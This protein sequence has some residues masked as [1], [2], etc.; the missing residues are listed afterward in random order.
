MVAALRDPAEQAY[1]KAHMSTMPTKMT[2]VH[3]YHL[4]LYKRALHPEL[5]NLKKRKLIPV[6]GGEFEAWLMPGSHV[7][8]FQ[9]RS[10]C[11]CE[12]VT[13]RN[14]GLPTN[15]A[16]ATFPCLG[17]K[18]FEHVFSEPGIT[19]VTSLQTE[20]LNENLYMQ[21]YREISQLSREVDGIVH[22]WESE[23]GQCLSLLEIQRHGRE[24]HTQAYHLLAQGGL[25]LRTQTILEC[26]K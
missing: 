13:D 26:K 16:V 6:P 11:V 9:I 8:R 5:V 20:T 24:V 21:S 12:L 17:E 7:L 25:V 22:A 14:D 1:R 23:A 19:Y 4:V 15:G 2:G 3:P 18:D 10:F